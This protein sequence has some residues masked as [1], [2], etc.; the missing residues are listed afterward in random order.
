MTEKTYEL[1]ADELAGMSSK[2]L[3]ELAKPQQPTVAQDLNV[4]LGITSPLPQVGG[5]DNFLGFSTT[6]EIPRSGLVPLDD[7]VLMIRRDGQA[8]ALLRLLTLPI[9]AA[10]KDS[11]WVAPDDAEDAD[12]EVEFANLMWRLPPQ[13]GGMTVPVT[14]F[15][16]QTLLALAHG[17]SAFEEV[18]HVPEDGPLKG[19]ITLRK[20]ALRDARSIRFKVDETGGFNG[21]QQRT[22]LNGRSIDVWIQPGKAW[23]YAASEEENPYYGVS[24]FEAAFQHYD[25]KRK[26]YYLA[27]LA[28]QFA[29]VPARVGEVPPNYNLSELR[30][31]KQALADFAANTA[32]THPSGYKVTM[33]NSASSFD[34]LKLIDHHNRM[35]SKSVLA[36]FIDTEDRP[37]LVDIAKSDPNADMF[38]LA[39]ESIMNEIADSWT[40]HI[41]PKYIDWNF[42]TAKYPVFRFGTLSDDDKGAIQSVFESVV[43]SSTLNCTPE[44]VRQMEMKLAKHFDLDINYDDIEKMEKQAAEQAQQNAQDE[45]DQQ[46]QLAQQAAEQVPQPGEAPQNGT[47]PAGPPSP[48]GPSAVAASSRDLDE[49]IE[50]A[51]N[52]LANF[53][54]ED[55]AA[56]GVLED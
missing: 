42:G 47:T 37:A 55:L 12:D 2:E 9:R 6:G 5:Y 52:I 22:T 38:V 48:Q 33:Q 56:P 16:R 24:M 25:I 11:Q 30:A 28:A 40:Q 4:E 34:F 7:L 21:F 26:L 43:N 49:L 53:E 39:L 36:G 3:V 32:M 18:R 27:H 15:L 51:Q 45:Q 10:L 23:Y 31:F 14:K 54:D 35:M 1:T 29:A 50:M 41:M 8:R 20:M 46:Q 44:F 13:S 17:Y 19:K